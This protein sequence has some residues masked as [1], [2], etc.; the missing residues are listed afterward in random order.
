M[1]GEVQNESRNGQ[2]EWMEGSEC[3]TLNSRK[4]NSIQSEGAGVMHNS[5]FG[6]YNPSSLW[7][8]S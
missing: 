1:K 5:Q 8:N 6:R 4:R 2:D 7:T 3:Q